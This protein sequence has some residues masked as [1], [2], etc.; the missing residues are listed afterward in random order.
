MRSS[1][2]TDRCV[3]CSASAGYDRRVVDREQLRRAFYAGVPNAR[4]QDPVFR[5]IFEFMF[6]AQRAAAPGT[7]LLNI[8]ASHD[9]SGERETVYRDEFFK[10]T[11]YASIDWWED[12]FVTGD[13]TAPAQHLTF[14][15][16]TFSTLVNTKVVLEHASNPRGVLAEFFRVLEPG[17]TAFLIAP[18]VRRQHQAPHDYF[19]Y[20][21]YGLRHLLETVGF[22]DISLAPTNGFVATAVSYAYFFQRGLNIPPWMERLLDMVTR[23]V[24]EP[25]GF[26][27]DR[28]DNGYGRDMT[29]YF[30]AQA[31]KPLLDASSG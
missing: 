8:Y 31:K 14:D 21:E 26:A 20:T 3:R 17:G 25:I 18:L 13:P 4:P 9:R 23:N 6:E 27:L 12:G 24:I 19:R 29:L 5:S 28:L 16:A 22:C 7:R 11:R 1:G 15:D 30:L 2:R 10:H